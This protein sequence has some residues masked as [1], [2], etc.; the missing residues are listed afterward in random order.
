MSKRRQLA[1]IG[2]VLGLSLGISALYS[3]V[4]IAVRVA[5]E[6]G[7]SEQTATLNRSISEFEWADVS[8]Q[9]L[10]IVSSLVPV[11]LV[12]FLLWQSTAPRLGALGLDGKKFGRDSLTGLGL[13]ALIGIPGLLLY[14]V[15]RE[16]D[17]TVTVVPT[18]LNAYWWTVPMLIALALRAGIL[19]EVIAVGYLFNRLASLGLSLWGIIVI[20]SLLRATYHLYQ[21]FG[22]FVGNFVMGLI[23]GYVYS[24]TGRLAPLI[25]GHTLIDIVAFVGYPVALGFFPEIL[26]IEG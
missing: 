16:L 23:F 11:A 5:R 8:Y 6:Q 12:V 24:K 9:L 1:E 10:G 3:I 19:E 14:L 17:V 18:A 7:L 20:Q 13:A 22:P 26:G 25:I 4:G 15:G 2:I 21:G